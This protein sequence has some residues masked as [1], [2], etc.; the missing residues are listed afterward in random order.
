MR[1]ATVAMLTRSMY[2]TKYIRQRT[3][4]TWLDTLIPNARRRPRQTLRM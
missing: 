1:G 2:I 3:I 4:R